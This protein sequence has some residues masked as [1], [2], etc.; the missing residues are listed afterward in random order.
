MFFY[1]AYDDKNKRNGCMF[2][3]TIIAPSKRGEGLQ[4]FI[5]LAKRNGKLKI[6]GIDTVP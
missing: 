6:T 3:Y 1:P 5:Y 2:P 4:G